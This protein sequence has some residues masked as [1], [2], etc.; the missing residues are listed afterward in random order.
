MNFW[1]DLASGVL[2]QLPFGAALSG[3]SH[4]LAARDARRSA[5]ENSRRAYD[6][7]RLDAERLRRQGEKDRARAAARVFA[8]GVSLSGSP[9]A[10][11]SEEEE[12]NRADVGDILR[13]GL[14]DANA[15]RRRGRYA[16]EQSYLNLA[17]SIFSAF[18]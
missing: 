5:K 10:V 14:E 6:T 15:I 7:A 17:G 4:L 2:S 11:L 13:F 9:M 12:I 18:G 3:A 8:S 1:K 16:Q